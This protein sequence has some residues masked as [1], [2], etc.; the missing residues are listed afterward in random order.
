MAPRVYRA[1]DP[2]PPIF[3]F[4][5]PP[6]AAPLTP[7]NKEIFTRLL[8]GFVQWMGKNNLQ[9]STVLRCTICGKQRPFDQML[10][11]YSVQKRAVLSYCPVCRLLCP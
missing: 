10:F 2:L 6:F 3:N 8:P 7:R 4:K 9:Y 11:I 5:A 1:C